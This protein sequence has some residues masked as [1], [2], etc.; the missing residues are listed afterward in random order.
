VSFDYNDVHQEWH[1]ESYKDAKSKE[2]KV[3]QEWNGAWPPLIASFPPIR[4]TTVLTTRG[5]DAAC[6]LPPDT[7][8]S[9]FNYILLMDV[10]TKLH[11]GKQGILSW[12]RLTHG[13]TQ[14]GSSVSYPAKV[15]ACDSQIVPPR[16]PAACAV[17]KPSN[18]NRRPRL[19]PLKWIRK[20]SLCVYPTFYPPPLIFLWNGLA[21][22]AL[23]STTLWLAFCILHTL[24]SILCWVLQVQNKNK[25]QNFWDFRLC[26]SSGIEN[27][28]LTWGGKQIQFPNSC[29]LVSRIPDDGQS[30]K[31]Q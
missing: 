4:N 25:C 8:L 11:N 23:F 5:L 6:L 3:K 18:N 16:G 30:P 31:T 1:D 28:T 7:R 2:T 20:S 26:S 12:P 15:E 22:C 27:T 19:Q 17:K 13:S 29:F 10:N 9:T 21:D 14:I 24:L